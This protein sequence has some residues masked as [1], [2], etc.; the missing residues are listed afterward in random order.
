MKRSSSL[1]LYR[2]NINFHVES[3]TSAYQAARTADSANASVTKLEL[4]LTR[5]QQIFYPFV[6][7]IT[8]YKI[9]VP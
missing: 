8:N 3:K 7:S 6:P 2:Q 1:S 9:F 4:F 5:K